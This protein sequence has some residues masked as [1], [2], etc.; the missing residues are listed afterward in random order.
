MIELVSQDLALP[1][2]RRF[3]RRRQPDQMREFDYWLE[4][5][6]NELHLPPAILFRLR[7]VVLVRGIQQHIEIGPA[8]P[9]LYEPWFGVVDDFDFAVGNQLF[10]FSRRVV[11]RN[12][13]AYRDVGIDLC[14]QFEGL[15]KSGVESTN[16]E[17]AQQHQQ[18]LRAHHPQE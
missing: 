12:W 18:T 15:A 1:D 11:I 9:S 6:D 13:L 14:R 10:E 4:L 8:S 2:L 5:V 3:E 17:P 7:Q 16:N